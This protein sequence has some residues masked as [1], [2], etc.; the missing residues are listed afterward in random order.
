MRRRFAVATPFGKA[1]TRLLCNLFIFEKKGQKVF[2][3]HDASVGHINGIE[4]R[5]QSRL[6]QFWIQPT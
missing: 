2:T 6:C 4:H 5:M 3:L 1:R